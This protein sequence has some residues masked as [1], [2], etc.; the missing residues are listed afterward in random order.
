MIF[1]QPVWSRGVGCY[2]RRG[3][4]CW[5]GRIGLDD[6]LLHVSATILF[7]VAWHIFLHLLG[8]LLLYMLG[9]ISWTIR[10][11]ILFE[12]GWHRLL[13]V[14]GHGLFNMGWDVSALV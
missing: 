6:F 9:Y 4:D 3:C 12:V 13:H 2:A 11:D 7:E 1:A 5:P 14:L 10:A 8:N